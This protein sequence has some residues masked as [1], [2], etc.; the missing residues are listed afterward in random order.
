MANP[1]RINGFAT[2]E[3]AYVDMLSANLL[4]RTGH[5]MLL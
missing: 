4:N 5:A 1:R 2:M 3:L